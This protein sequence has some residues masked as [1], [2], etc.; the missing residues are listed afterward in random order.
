MSALPDA[1][2]G[3]LVLWQS[4]SLLLCEPARP[5]DPGMVGGEFI[6]N[7]IPSHGPAQATLSEEQ[8]NS[9]R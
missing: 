5:M 6:G 8:R 4:E 2:D 9:S 1:T 3:F 7:P